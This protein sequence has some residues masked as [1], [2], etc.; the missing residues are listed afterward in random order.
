MANCEENRKLL[1]AMADAWEYCDR[2]R[3]RIA[4]ND[5]EDRVAFEA[6]LTDARLMATRLSSKQNEHVKA[7]PICCTLSVQ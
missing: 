5:S 2:I 3:E 6:E 7:C 4:L 1:K